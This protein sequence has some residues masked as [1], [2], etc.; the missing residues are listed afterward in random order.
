MCDISTIFLWIAAII[1]AYVELAPSFSWGFFVGYP[2]SGVICG[3]QTEIPVSLLSGDDCISGAG[4]HV[5]CLDSVRSFVL[6]CRATH[7]C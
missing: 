7:V 1:H 2:L 5:C 4:A 3:V 6:L